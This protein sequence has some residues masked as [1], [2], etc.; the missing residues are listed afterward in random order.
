MHNLNYR[1]GALPS[2][3]FLGCPASLSLALFASVFVAR[4][5]IWRPGTPGVFRCVPEA[6]SSKPAVTVVASGS[7]TLQHGA[8]SQATL[9]LS[10]QSRS[11]AD[12][13]YASRCAFLRP[14]P[15]DPVYNV[16]VD[17]AVAVFHEN[18]S[19]VNRLSPHWTPVLLSRDDEANPNNV[20]PNLAFEALPY[21]R[22]IIRH[23]DCLP[24]R[25][26]FLHAENP[27]KHFLGATPDRKADMVPAL[28]ALKLS[29]SRPYTPLS[30]FGW[31]STNVFDPLTG[32]IT[33]YW[34]EMHSVFV[35]SGLED[36]LGPMP[37]NISAESYA[38]F[39]V[40]RDAIHRGPLQM[41][42]RLDE[43]LSGGIYCSS[44]RSPGSLSNALLG[45]ACE[46]MSDKEV[47]M[48]MEWLWLFIFSGA[49][50]DHII[51][52]S[53]EIYDCIAHA[54]PPRVYF[55]WV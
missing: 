32:E 20:L 52:D 8:T 26:V 49:S 16:T 25:V 21:T 1:P 40:T 2:R 11:A 23:Y 12:A 42:R 33:R 3:L 19:W 24:D 15:V 22:Y 17:V 10:P 35:A 38:Q 30:L 36:F 51:K 5:L 45:P 31:H 46:C 28:L 55:P 7:G 41:W 13:R 54:I 4:L 27:S 48:E 37:F 18:T 44:A 9:T 6:L 43:W 29:P 47:A 14:R 39:L 50:S 34:R 53:C